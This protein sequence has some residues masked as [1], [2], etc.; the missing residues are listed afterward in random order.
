MEKLAV[1]GVCDLCVHSLSMAN[2][3]FKVWL[4]G[5]DTARG[6]EFVTFVENVL[7]GNEITTVAQLADVTAESISYE[8]MGAVTAGVL[9][10]A[11]SARN[12]L[13]CVVLACR[14]E[15]FY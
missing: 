3:S 11:A 1:V 2:V 7:V 15:S 14:K 10:Q 12:R 6:A 13:W 5:I 9:S 8:G 4:A